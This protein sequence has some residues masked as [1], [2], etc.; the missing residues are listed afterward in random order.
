MRPLNTH[1]PWT[2]FLQA[3][4]SNYEVLFPEMKMKMPR[5]ELRRLKQFRRFHF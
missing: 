2:N 3:M 4:P 1:L 5:R